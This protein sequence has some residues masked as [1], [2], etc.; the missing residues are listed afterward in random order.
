MSI[1]P[2]R[3]AL[4]L[5]FLSSASSAAPPPPVAVPPEFNGPIDGYDIP[6]LYQIWRHW[7]EAQKGPATEALT[8]H[9][10][11]RDGERPWGRQVLRITYGNDFGH[12][13]TADVRLYCRARGPYDVD[14]TACHLR[15]RRAFVPHD[16]GVYGTENPLSLWMRQNF[17]PVRLVAHLRNIGLG[18]DTD[19]WRADRARIFAGL[20]SPA[21]LLRD[22]ATVVRVDSRDCRHFDETVRRLERTRLELPLDI[23][24]IGAD[25]RPPAPAP[26]SGWVTYRI[27]TFTP[28]GF[29]EIEGWGG[30]LADLV[31]PIVE[32]VE[33]CERAQA[34]ANPS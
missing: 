12:V 29:A 15:Y 25:Q 34:R 9:P 8:N 11:Q 26:H 23:A 28:N 14:R 30:Y 27:A 33:R 13:M 20:P 2:R 10:E 3:L 24:G 16:A 21:Q 6:Q 5:A 1:A 7:L 18:S 31:N 17:D 22:Q 32:A 4:A 19:W